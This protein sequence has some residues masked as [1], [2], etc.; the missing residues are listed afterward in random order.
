MP[1]FSNHLSRVTRRS[2][3]ENIKHN[4]HYM[5]RLAIVV[6]IAGVIL[7]GIAFL[8]TSKVVYVQNEPT[9]VEKTVEVDALDEAIKSAQKGKL[10]EIEAS[11]QK[12]YDEAYSQEMKK[13]ELEV[14]RS[15]G[16]KLDARQVELEKETKI[17]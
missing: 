2:V 10:S 11:A 8:K 3:T 9:V 5:K 12:A 13:V 1:S 4:Q 6:M 15:F 14:I 17:Y 16:E 7:G